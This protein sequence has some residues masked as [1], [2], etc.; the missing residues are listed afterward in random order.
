MGIYPKN[1]I[2]YSHLPEMGV[3]QVFAYRRNLFHLMWC[4]KEIN[5]VCVNCTN[6]KSEHFSPLLNWCFCCQATVKV[7]SNLGF[8]YEAVR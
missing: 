4:R 2:S 7:A 1:S 6:R 8:Q 5:R 3:M